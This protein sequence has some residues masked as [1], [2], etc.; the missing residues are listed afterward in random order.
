MVQMH[1]VVVVG[2]I[3]FGHTIPMVVSSTDTWEVVKRHIQTVT[4][5]RT[6]WFGLQ[7]Q[8][9][10]DRFGNLADDPAASRRADHHHRFSIFQNDCRSH[11]RP[12]PFSGL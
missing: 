11:R 3:L 7:I 5:V 4:G 8:M 2:A 9:G 6:D 10:D 12:W 1:T